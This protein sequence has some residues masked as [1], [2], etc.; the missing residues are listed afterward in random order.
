VALAS[1][2]APPPS[3]GSGEFLLTFLKMLPIAFVVSALLV[4]VVTAIMKSKLKSV[5]MQAAADSYIRR[6]SLKITERRDQFLYKTVK[7]SARNT[8]SSS[9]SGRRRR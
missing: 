2:G 7:K 9:S 6:D 1:D 4:F 3:E 5:R 8:S